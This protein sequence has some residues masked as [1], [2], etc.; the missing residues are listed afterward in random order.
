MQA[1]DFEFFDPPTL[2][3]EAERV[4]NA[5]ATGGCDPE[6]LES[7]A[8]DLKEEAGRRS[9]GAIHPGPSENERAAR[10]LAQEAACMANT[11]GGGVL[12]VGVDGRTGEIIGAD[13]EPGWLR[14]RIYEL[15][16]RRLT[17]NIRVAGVRG[18]RLLVISVPQAVEPVPFKGK[19]R[20]RLGKAC[21]E[22]TSTELLRGIFAGAAADPSYQRSATPSDAVSPRTEAALRGRLTQGDGL[23]TQSDLD[24]AALP[25]RD[26]LIRLGLVFE[27]TEY[28]N[29]AGRILLAAGRSPTLDY[30]YREV[31]GGPSSVRIYE[32]GLSLLEQIELVV[33]EANR[34]NPITEITDG[35]KVHRVRA[36]PHRSLREAILNGVC[37]RDWTDPAPTVVEHIGYELRVTSPGGLMR[38]ITV[39]NIIT[40]PSVPR[41]RTLMNAVRQVGLVEQEGMG[42][43]RMF[44]DLIRIGNTP[45]LIELT[46]DPSVRVI[47]SGRRPDEDRYRFFLDLQPRRV[48]DDVDTAL[49]VWRAS[50]PGTPFLTAESCAPLLQRSPDDA[51][52]ALHRVAEYKLGGV[53]KLLTPMTTPDGSPPAWV[54]S[55][56]AR[57]ALRTK[58]SSEPSIPALAWLQERG[59]ISSTE[60]REITGFS[61]ATAV[62]HL[63]VLAEAG[64]MKP[65]RPSGRGR[66]FHYLLPDDLRGT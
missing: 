30:T 17:V 48:F 44:A 7:A 49:A 58:P 26:L 5:L 66:G 32:T 60:Y 50:Q 46:D 38:G 33:A 29:E 40:H 24:K 28:L 53:R 56:A 25:L 41:Y 63:K 14:T 59:R 42:V 4:L 2:D 39:G 55:R 3:A 19:Y 54:L 61:H 34:N 37:H 36:I 57:A 43:D 64:R 47:L 65:S 20:H 11:A 8:V 31:P 22:V 27:D 23:P 21:V 62:A 15:T 51:E 35:P 6:S 13:T 1:R 18:K 16:D 12:I 10:Q 52:T 9:N 45:P